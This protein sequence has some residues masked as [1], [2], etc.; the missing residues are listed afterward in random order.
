MGINAVTKSLEKQN[1]CSI[2]VDSNIDPLFMIK[3][4]VT[5]GQKKNVPVLLVPFLKSV[6]LSK[7]KFACAAV[8]L[9][10]ELL[11]INYVYILFAI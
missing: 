3:H 6:T 5:M 7:I 2:I 8:G 9:K 4:I 1:L 10:V 11:I